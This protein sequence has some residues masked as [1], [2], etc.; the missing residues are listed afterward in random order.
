MLRQQSW[1]DEQTEAQKS[2]IKP[3]ETRSAYANLAATRAKAKAER[4]FFLPRGLD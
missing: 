2:T 3:Y 1:F 4:R